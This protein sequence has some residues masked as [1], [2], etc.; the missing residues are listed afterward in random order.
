MNDNR[1]IFEIYQQL[2]HDLK[3]I[4]KYMDH[5]TLEKIE[6]N[7]EATVQTI[8]EVYLLVNDCVKYTGLNLEKHKWTTDEVTEDDI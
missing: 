4:A 2:A 8:K 3:V 7:R 1:D 5:C 6:K